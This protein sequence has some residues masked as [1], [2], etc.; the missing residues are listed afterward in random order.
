MTVIRLSPIQ[1]GKADLKMAT[2]NEQSNSR[3]LSLPSILIVF[4]AICF[5]VLLAAA[6]PVHSRN[7]QPAAAEVSSQVQPA[8]DMNQ[9]MIHKT[10]KPRA[11]K[12]KIVKDN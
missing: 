10:A 9:P 5:L 7:S 11:G 2:L 1:V 6:R 12:P 4:T 8:T 3:F